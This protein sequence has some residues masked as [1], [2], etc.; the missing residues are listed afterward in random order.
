MWINISSNHNKFHLIHS[1]QFY[2]YW[3]HDHW[4]MCAGTWV[5]L[6]PTLCCVY[7]SMLSHGRHCCH[8]HSFR[9]DPL[10]NFG[11][12]SSHVLQES[13]S[14]FMF[15]SS[16]WNELCA[17]AVVQYL[18]LNWLRLSSFNLSD[19]LFHCLIFLLI[20][21]AITFYGIKDLLSIYFAQNA[22]TL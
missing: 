15:K 11:G 8:C 20:C 10:S 13:W 5:F 3:N 21:I 14:W 22:Y 1:P 18:Q 19:S 4:L 6:N 9:D 12:Q 2:V 16:N 7:S 17:R